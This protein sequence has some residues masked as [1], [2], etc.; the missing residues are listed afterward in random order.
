MNLFDASALL[1]FLQGEPGASVVE[2]QLDVGSAV[3]AATNWSEV[4]QKV[5]SRDGDWALA[6]SLLLGYDLAV[7][8]VTAIDAE[9]AAALW[10][11]GSGRSL[12]DRICLSMGT[13]LD[14]VVWTAD[15]DWGV[16][17]GLRQVR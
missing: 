7:E 10:R 5:R 4:A 13:R 12:A 15:A 14:A 3:C 1:C 2:A 8:P 16:S 11:R 17:E 9:A 6:R